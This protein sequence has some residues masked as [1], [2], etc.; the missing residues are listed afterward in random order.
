MRVVQ[1]LCSQVSFLAQSVRCDIVRWCHCCCP[2][3]PAALCCPAPEGNG[4][5]YAVALLDIVR[6][7]KARFPSV[8]AALEPSASAGPTDGSLEGGGARQRLTAEALFPGV[9][10]DLLDGKLQEVGCPACSS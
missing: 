1:E 8:L 9:S 10:A 2:I 5:S 7:Y 4:W 3:S 6:E